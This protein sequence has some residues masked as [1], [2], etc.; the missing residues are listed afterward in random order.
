M[1]EEE[2]GPPRGG[3]GKGVGILK[4]SCMEERKGVAFRVP[5]GVVA[6]SIEVCGYIPVSMGPSILYWIL[7]YTAYP[8]LG[9]P[10]MPPVCVRI[11]RCLGLVPAS[12]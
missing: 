12:L 7:V 2:F 11:C 5:R 10:L 9:A 3:G 6:R 4:G 8:Y 1:R